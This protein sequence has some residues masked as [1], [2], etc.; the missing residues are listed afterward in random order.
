MPVRVCVRVCVY[1]RA[2]VCVCQSK[3]RSMRDLLTSSSKANN[4]SFFRL[5]TLLSFAQMRFWEV[6]NLRRTK[7]RVNTSLSLLKLFFF[8]LGETE[9]KSLPH[10]IMV[11]PSSQ[12][13]VRTK[14]GEW[15][16]FTDFP[17]FF[18]WRTTRKGCGSYSG[19]TWHESIIHLIRFFRS[20]WTSTSNEKNSKTFKKIVLRH[21]KSSFFCFCCFNYLQC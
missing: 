10:L 1:M 13:W 7:L 6:S 14:K 15:I 4:K 19:I 8:V 12:R 18:I 2:C 21:L 20:N 5:L 3:R 17:G 9:I 16:L 11:F